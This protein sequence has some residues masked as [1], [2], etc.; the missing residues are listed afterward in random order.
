MIALEAKRGEMYKQAFES[1]KELTD[2]A[3]KLA[4]TANKKG[5]FDILGILGVVAIVAATI[6]SIL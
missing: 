5:S 3:L 1:E 6:A 4:E 2:R